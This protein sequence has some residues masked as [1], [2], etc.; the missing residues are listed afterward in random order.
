MIKNKE[1]KQKRTLRGCLVYWLKLGSFTVFALYI[2]YFILAVEYS[3][4]PA[5]SD[6]CCQTPADAGFAYET[7]QFTGGDGVTLTGW[8]IPSQNGAAVILLHGYDANRLQMLKHSNYLAQHGYGVL[9]YDL[10]GHGGSG[11]DKRAVGWPD[12]PDVAAAV[13]F[14]T[15]KPEIEANRIGIFGFSVGGQIAIR[16]AAELE[17]LQAV[18]SDGSAMVD[19]RDSPLP[20]SVM[21]GVFYVGNFVFYKGMALRSGMPAPASV[22][23]TIGNIAPRSILLVATGGA[24]GIEQRINKAYF[25]AAQE[26]KQLWGIPEAGHGTGFRS[27]P[28]E[29]ETQ[30]ITFFDEALLQ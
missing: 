30:L 5:P 7:V 9:L 16:A 2:A 3:V 28:E 29:Y 20:N 15:D 21:E 4:R 6:V 1:R 13:T 10:R 19:N 23:E 11:G 26:P 27:R 25:E 18:V 17:S 22:R 8:Y 12:V 24:D 14:L